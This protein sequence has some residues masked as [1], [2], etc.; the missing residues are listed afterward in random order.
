M[1]TLSYILCSGQA[2]LGLF[3]TYA[4]NILCDLVRAPEDLTRT[5][6]IV[7]PPHPGTQRVLVH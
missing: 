2:F 7:C 1:K 5:R 6:R 3:N 4:A